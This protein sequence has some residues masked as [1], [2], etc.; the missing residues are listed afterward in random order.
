MTDNTKPHVKINI[1]EILRESLVLYK[2][3][4]RKLII[5]GIIL[6]RPGNAMSWIGMLSMDFSWREESVMVLSVLFF[7]TL[8]WIEA[9]LVV[10]CLKLVRKESFCLKMLFITDFKAIRRILSAFIVLLI[11]FMVFSLGFLGMSL[12]IQ[13]PGIVPNPDSFLNQV[14]YLIPIAVFAV[15]AMVAVWLLAQV[16]FLFLD[17]MQGLWESIKNSV[18]L[19]RKRLLEYFLLIIIPIVFAAILGNYTYQIAGVF[20]CPWLWLIAALYYEKL[21]QVTAPE[22]IPDTENVPAV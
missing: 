18:S 21:M 14:L 4:F 15:L 2:T 22:K 17:M 7:F 20:T 3:Q 11:A 16:P 1:F 5:P 13:S 6:T 12:Y 19:M 8:I 9:G 10:Y